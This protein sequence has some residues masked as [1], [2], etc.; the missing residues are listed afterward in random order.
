[1]APD[2]E[3]TASASKPAPSKVGLV[4]DPLFTKHHPG[5]GHPEQI[6]RY[7]AITR[8]LT[9]TGL[10]DRC[11]R[12][13]PRKATDAE[14]ELA[15]SGAY[16]QLAVSEIQAGATQLSTGDTSVC[17][18]SL[19]VALNAAGA[20]C[21]M[22]DAL[23]KKRFLRGFCALRPPG[24]HATPTKG[25]GFCIFNNVAIAARYAQQR[26]EKIKRVA[27]VDWDVHHGNGTQDIFYEDDSVHFFSTHQSP[28][29]PGTGALEETGKGKGAGLTLNRPFPAGSGMKEIGGAFSNEWEEA[30]NTFKPNLI[31]ISAGFDSRIDDPLGNF[32]LTDAD[33]TELTRQVLRVADKHA[34]GR[35]LSCLEGGYNVEGLASA[36]CAHVEALLETS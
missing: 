23:L 12:L 16:R 3:N 25:M 35:V 22:V 18:D 15:H 20:V 4:L 1:M 29:Y 9:K 24:H 27:I 10:A 13:A 33:F 11:Q 21:D 8:R 28:L 5:P 2:R 26:D 30:M 19:E 17:R 7:E 34:D 31:I 6:A 14:I 36:V 32:T